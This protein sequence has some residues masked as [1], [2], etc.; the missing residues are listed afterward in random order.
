MVRY[1]T[2]LL[3]LAGAAFGQVTQRN[4]LS[5][6]FSFEDVKASLIPQAKWHPYPTIPSEWKQRVPQ[7]ELDE[8]VKRGEVALKKEI[9]QVTATLLLEYVRNGNRSRYEEKSFARRNNLMDLVLAESVEGKGRFT[10]A[11]ANYVWT[12]CEETYWGV[13]AHLGVQK[14]RNGLPDVTDPIVELFGAETAATL[15]L[16]DYFV[17]PKLDAISP[18]I[19]KRI[20][21]E[22][23]RKI[24]DP[25]K[26]TQRYSWLDPTKKVN[27]WNPWIM[28]NVMTAELLLEPDETKR[29]ENL[30]QYMKLLDVYLN[31]LGDNGGCDEGPSYWFAAGGSVFDALETLQSAT[32]NRIEIYNEPLVQ[33]MASY[34]YKMHI[35]DDY[36]VD[37]ADADPRFKGDGLML[38][39]F[40]KDIKD[41]T[42]SQ[43][44]LYLYSRHKNTIGEGFQKP[45]R[46]NDLLTIRELQADK[47]NYLP[48]SE[49]WFSDIQVLTARTKSGLFLA[50]HGGNNGESHNHNDVGDFIIYLGNEPVIIDA[51]RGNYTAKTFS[52][53]RYELWFTQSQYHN[54]PIINGAGQSAGKDYAAKQVK[55]LTSDTGVS[56]AMDISGAYPKDAG[57]NHWNRIVKLDRTNGQVDI[58]DDYLLTKTPASLQQIFMTVCNVDLKEPGII[59]LTTPTGKSVR[60]EYDQNILTMSLDKPSMEG[61]EYS[62]FTSKWNNRPIQRILLTGRNPKA[63]GS[64]R[65]TIRES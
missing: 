48:A 60:L 58:S 55:Y 13:P 28:S 51:G 26:Q 38:Y 5:G 45:R 25:I 53:H 11:I 7:N 31:G 44:G 61:R 39:R 32:N 19:R 36:F 41:N 65:Y 22:A 30:Y 50:T 24:L 59:K 64:I 56:L 12:I 57:I 52:S 15:A 49:A 33:K 9:P 2:V 34:I 43:F 8:I 21:L 17:G 27:N 46:I 16:T 62:S 23:N 3:F 63:K 18:L 37:F 20:Y 4:L 6:H 40:G 54:L 10:D 1:I 47:V 14:A 35:A 29:S 42:L